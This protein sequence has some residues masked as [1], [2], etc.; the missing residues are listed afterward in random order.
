[1][2]DYLNWLRFVVLSLLFFMV[3]SCNQEQKTLSTPDDN[4]SYLFIDPIFTEGLNL[5][6]ISKIELAIYEGKLVMDEVVIDSIYRDNYE[7][8]RFGK[9]M[10]L[11][12]RSYALNLK[13]G[14]PVF[15]VYR[16]NKA[17]T[18]FHY[19]ESKQKY[20]AGHVFDTGRG[21]IRYS[22]SF[23][24]KDS[25]IVSKL[26]QYKEPW[27]FMF[28]EDVDLEHNYYDID[29]TKNELINKRVL[30]M[31]SSNYPDSIVYMN[32]NRSTNVRVVEYFYY[33]NDMKLT[34][35][36]LMGE[37]YI[38]KYD[39]KGLLVSTIK[40][41]DGYFDNDNEPI[42]VTTE[43]TYEYYPDEINWERITIKSI[44]QIPFLSNSKKIVKY[45]LLTRDISYIGSNE[46]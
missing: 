38:Y 10:L 29:P 16:E 11:Q 22:S 27:S 3:L 5:Q 36:N 44:K 1:M 12:D 4:H 8:N 21:Y 18:T 19:H 43:S 2:N 17:N 26:Y 13:K 33:N 41:E 31:N 35:R 24:K 46:N 30:H 39:Q 25:V 23:D 34:H 45:F 40:A 14:K 32:K 7:I 6:E 9:S 37:S 15:Q 20:I 42:M 28:K